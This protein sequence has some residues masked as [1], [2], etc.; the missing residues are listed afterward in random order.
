V[1]PVLWHHGCLVTTNYYYVPM[2]GYLMWQV[3]LKRLSLWNW[4]RIC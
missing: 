1:K 4:I 3:N 2:I